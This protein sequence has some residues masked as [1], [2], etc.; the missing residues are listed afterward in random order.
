MGIHFLDSFS[1]IVAPHEGP[2]MLRKPKET[3]GIRP[4]RILRRI[5]DAGGGIFWFPAE[6]IAFFYIPVVKLIKS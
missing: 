2:G 3:A 1:V 5:S 6:R 4:G